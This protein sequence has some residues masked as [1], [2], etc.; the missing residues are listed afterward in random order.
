MK[1]QP[2]DWVGD[3]RLTH[4]II[5]A[6]YYVYNRL[7]PGFLESIYLAAL[8]RVLIRRGFKVA[9]E[10]LIPIHFDNEIIG[11]QRADMVVNDCVVVEGKATDA[12]V[13]RDHVQL[14]GYLK[15]TIFEIGLL[16]HFGPRAQFFRLAC[17]ND[18]KQLA[19]PRN[20]V[21]S[22]QSASRKPS[23]RPG[24]TEPQPSE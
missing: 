15:A 23:N 17:S 7:G 10:V 14:F 13:K 5:A 22:A 6:F 20:P 2:R 16:L 11:Y 8:E 19:D 12:L 1:T 9:R 4:A 3:E 18:R 24:I 21:V